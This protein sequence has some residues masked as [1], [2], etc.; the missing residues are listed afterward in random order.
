MHQHMYR[1]NRFVFHVVA[2][3]V[4]ASQMASELRSQTAS[5][6]AP[7][8]RLERIEPSS[9]WVGMKNPTVQVLC[10]GTN[11]G[12]SAVRILQSPSGVQVTKVESVENPNY[13]F[14]TLTIAPKTKAGNV[15]LQ[16][17]QQITKTKSGGAFI[18]NFALQ[19]RLGKT[20]TPRFQGFSSAD[21]IYLL[22]P[23]RFSNGD[24]SND[25]IAG[26][27]DIMHRDSM[28]ARHGGDIQGI[29]NHLDYIRDLGCTAL[30]STPLLENNQERYSYHGYG[31]T[32][33]Y[34]IDRRFGSNQTYKQLVD[35]AHSKGLK[36]IKDMVLNHCGDRHWMFQDPPT[37][38]WF[39]DYAAYKASSNWKKDVRKPNY[40][41]STISDPH[42]SAY[43]RTGMSDRWFD[44]MLPDLNQKNPLLATY[45]IQNSIW[46]IE[47][48]GIDGIRMDT[49]PYP[50]K[51]FSARWAKAILN[52][53]PRFGIVGEVWIGESIGM[54]AYWLAGTTNRDG[55]ASGL[56][57]A[58]D[59]P[60][61]S[62]LTSAFNEKEGWGE[63]LVRIYNTLAGDF[64]Y[65]QPNSNLIFLD[66]HDLGRA[67][68][69]LGEDVKKFKLALTILL[70]TRGTPQLYYGT[71][72]AMPGVKNIDPN[73]R[74]DHPGGWA[75]DK[76]DAF[77][78]QGRTERENEVFDLMRTLLR[79][80]KTKPAVQTGSLTHF[81][82]HDGIYTYFR[83]SAATGAAAGA[84]V[85]TA[86]AGDDAVMVMVNNSDREQRVNTS[87]YA[88]RLQGFGKARNVVT[89]EVI[90]D[91]STIVIAPKAALVLDLMK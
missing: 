77:T 82:P 2:L 32:D 26:M 91:L 31:I 12:S 37:S 43:D 59:F 11:I 89:G 34:A 83:H 40:R 74:K 38:D 8:F 41:S 22:M 18:T 60:L 62:A 68:S 30:W 28:D 55:F 54:T 48:S 80:R 90:A 29:V 13:L 71:E 5:S 35:T 9:W 56:P 24:P 63:G 10:H 58:T 4:I 1:I 17:T 69:S 79:W 27:P 73:V 42:A 67:F 49:Y 51:E 64:Q 47:F 66:N 52:E 44:W 25:T 57:S 6:A 3:M 85:K 88:E 15:I 7:A 16:F 75:G 46:W 14:V 86:S 65:P 39:N 81:V 61:M 21:A 50:D 72:L 53:Y 20:A 78:Q 36:V 76:R 87:R 33:F 70:T 19:E 23:D 45:L 84:P